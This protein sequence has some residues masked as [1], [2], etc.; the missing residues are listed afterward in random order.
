MTVL[1]RNPTVACLASMPPGRPSRVGIDGDLV[2]CSRQLEL[3]VDARG[4]P[5]SAH[6]M[7][8]TWQPGQQTSSVA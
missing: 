6:G 1:A 7:A 4:D 3:A 5:P 8:E 2:M